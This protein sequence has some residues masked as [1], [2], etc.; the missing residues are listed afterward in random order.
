MVRYV[1]QGVLPECGLCCGS[2]LLLKRHQSIRESASWKK[3]TSRIALAVGTETTEMMRYYYMDNGRVT[4]H[5][6]FI[7]Y[8]SGL[9]RDSN[10][11]EGRRRR[12]PEPQK[13]K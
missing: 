3:T 8:L 5:F 9:D 10:L 7:T 1:Q 11:Y 13:I 6:F 12:A 4:V 2:H